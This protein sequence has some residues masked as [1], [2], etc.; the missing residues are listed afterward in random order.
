MALYVD[1]LGKG[2]GRR[3]RQA[4]QTYAVVVFSAFL[5]SAHV[6]S[7]CLASFMECIG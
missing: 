4:E 1:L 3:Q 2:P 7:Q 5:M 6:D